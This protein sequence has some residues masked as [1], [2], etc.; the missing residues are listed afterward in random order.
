MSIEWNEL[1]TSTHSEIRELGNGRLREP[2]GAEILHKLHALSTPS[3]TAGPFGCCSIWPF[4]TV[5]QAEAAC[6]GRPLTAVAKHLVDVPVIDA[7]AKD[8]KFTVR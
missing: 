1:L 4:E 6:I 2:D 8:A 7:L 5:H 3:R